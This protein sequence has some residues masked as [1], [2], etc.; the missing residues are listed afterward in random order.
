MQESLDN[1]MGWVRIL[2]HSSNADKDFRYAEWEFASEAQICGILNYADEKILCGPLTMYPD[3]NG[4]YYYCLKIKYPTKGFEEKK[5]RKSGYY[6]KEGEVGELLALFSLFFQ[7]RFYKVASYF[8]ELN[9]QNTKIK[10]SY[11]FLH[12]KSVDYRQH[13]TVF[14]DR[15]R[16]FAEGL[17]E[18]L[19]LIRTLKPSLHESF[20]LA[21]YRY[22]QA[23]QLIGMDDPELIFIKLSTAI[24]I[25]LDKFE[26]PKG[27]NSLGGEIFDDVFA[28][29]SLTQEQTNQLKSILRVD[30]NG[31]IKYAPI[32]IKFIEFIYAHTPHYFETRKVEIPSRS[33]MV[34]KDKELK[35]RT[36]HSHIT[37]EN[38]KEILA[39]I[40]NA[41]SRN[42]HD[43]EIM[44]ASQIMYM[45][46]NC[47][48]DATLG[49][50]DDNKKFEHTELLPYA[51]S[52]EDIVRHSLL[53]YL[54]SNSKHQPLTLEP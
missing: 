47:D 11:N 42:L 32:T 31:I 9:S 17:Q 54:K 18:F 48:F 53:E 49:G 4:L 39:I 10:T 15:D 22:S 29:S 27:T 12:V 43:G 21:C 2:D 20:I 50:T 46:H 52:F 38:L 45:D 28:K 16:N 44:Y 34:E 5:P 7:A 14:K 51:H 13:P 25:L 24:E 40:Y 6:F 8:G 19:D 30:K 23:L 37:P 35:E 36:K 3:A 33:Y 26:L 41:R 1:R